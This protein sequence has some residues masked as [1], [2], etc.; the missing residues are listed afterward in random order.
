[1]PGIWK[2]SFE[3][4]IRNYFH[5]LR[6][7]PD[8]LTQLAFG[9][10][11]GNRRRLLVAFDVV[12]LNVRAGAGHLDGER[13]AG[14]MM[15]GELDVGDVEAGLARFVGDSDT[16]SLVGVLQVHLRRSL[17]RHREAT[18]A[19]L[20]GVDQDLVQLARLA[21]LQARA[22]QPHIL[23][24]ANVAIE[25]VDLERRAVDHVAQLFDDHTVL[26]TLARRERNAQLVV[27]QPFE[28]ARLLQARGRHNAGVQQFGVLLLDAQR[29]LARHSDRHLR[30]FATLAHNLRREG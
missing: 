23:G 16:R 10:H 22:R 4:K 19:R 25:H 30:P 7:R 18:V 11:V 20:L 24:I 2:A 12:A 8:K 26:A 28:E 21:L 15:V 17:D 29:H 6:H 27:V 14:H 3:T 5:N 9:A 13:R 1:M